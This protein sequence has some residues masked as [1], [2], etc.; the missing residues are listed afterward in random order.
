MKLGD[1]LET[2]IKIVT[3]GQGK[4]IATWIA[5]KLGYEDC[6]CDQRKNYLNGITRDGTKTK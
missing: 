6:G 1:K 5:D 3:F 2:I 4:R